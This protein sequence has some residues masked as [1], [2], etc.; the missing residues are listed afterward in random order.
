MPGDLPDTGALREQVMDQPVMLL[1]TPCHRA[2][3]LRWLNR[4]GLLVNR[5][6]HRFL[7][8][9]LVPGDTPLDGL[10]QVLP[11][12]EPIRDLHRVGR[13]A[14]CTLKWRWPGPGR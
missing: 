6:D 12:M 13:S 7:Q 1:P 4:R 8:T 11:Q 2:V 5:R 3:W 9:A 10:G 14:S